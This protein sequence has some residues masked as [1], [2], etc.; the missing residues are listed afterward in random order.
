M[1][2]SHSL[3]NGIRSPDDLFSGQ[4]QSYNE[5]E[6]KIVEKRGT[7]KNTWLWNFSLNDFSRGGRGRNQQNQQKASLVKFVKILLFLSTCR[8]DLTVM[9][10]FFHAP[11]MLSASR[12]GQEWRNLVATATPKESKK[13]VQLCLK[14]DQNYNELE[15]RQLDSLRRSHAADK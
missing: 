1:I 7:H 5:A 15:A 8:R 13:H 12:T 2:Y 3:A 9:W 4:C 10:C 11:Q 6:R 14:S